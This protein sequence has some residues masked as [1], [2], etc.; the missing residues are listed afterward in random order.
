MIFN[1]DI[2]AAMV[3]SYWIKHRDQMFLAI[4]AFMTLDTVFVSS[5]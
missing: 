3:L 4:S 2:N 1:M 5:R